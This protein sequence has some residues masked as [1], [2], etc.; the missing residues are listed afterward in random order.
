MLGIFKTNTTT[1]MPGMA[2]LQCRNEIVCGC[3]LCGTPTQKPRFSPSEMRTLHW[4]M[5]NP[6]WITGNK[7]WQNSIGFVESG[8]LFVK[9]ETK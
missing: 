3:V 1:T 4:A 6:Q 9:F 2:Q 5:Y 8:S 7:S